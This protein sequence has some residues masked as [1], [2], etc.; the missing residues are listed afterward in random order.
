MYR[1]TEQSYSEHVIQFLAL[2]FCTAAWGPAAS[3]FILAFTKPHDLNLVVTLLVLTVA[4]NSGTYTGFLSN[5]VE[6]S[7][8]YC[9]TLMGITNSLATVTSMIAPLSVGWLV[10]DDVKVRMRKNTCDSCQQYKNNLRSHVGPA[11]R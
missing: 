10:T 2:L 1:I 6:L 5:H 4:M 9:G 7:A 3:L 11:F 8:N